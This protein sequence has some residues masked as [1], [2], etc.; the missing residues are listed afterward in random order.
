MST[1]A[2]A[3]RHKLYD[4]IRVAEDKKLF[5]IYNLLENE[6]EETSEWWKDK[7]IVTELDCRY[8][9]LETGSDKGYNIE[10]LETSIGKLRNA[11][12]GK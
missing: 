9:A 4:Y 5:A 3:I 11:K 10:Q 2:S 1:A 7:Q 8:Q 6:I 12:Y